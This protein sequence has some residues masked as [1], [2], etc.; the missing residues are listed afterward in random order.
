MR[1][2]RNQ[3]N[4]RIAPTRRCCATERQAEIVAAD[5]LNASG[6][7][8]FAEVRVPTG[9][10]QPDGVISGAAIAALAHGTSDH[11]VWLLQACRNPELW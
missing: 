1:S 7:R 9:L 5:G 11:A 3:S 6:F 4:A 10:K 2:P 8:D